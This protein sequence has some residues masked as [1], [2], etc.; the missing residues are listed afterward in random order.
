MQSK[1]GR[2]STSRRTE[3][4]NGTEQWSSANSEYYGEDEGE[5]QDI[6]VNYDEEEGAY[7]SSQGHNEERGDSRW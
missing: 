2:T 1:Y 6:D 4:G 3:A 5:D 7:E